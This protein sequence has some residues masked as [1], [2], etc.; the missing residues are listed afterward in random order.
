MLTIDILLWIMSLLLGLASGYLTRELV[1]RRRRKRW[2]D[3]RRYFIE[4]PRLEMDRVHIN[5]SHTGTAEHLPDL[6]LG[7][8]AKCAEPSIPNS[9]G[10][11][12]SPVAGRT[13]LFTRPGRSAEARHRLTTSAGSE[14]NASSTRHTSDHVISTNQSSASRR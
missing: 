2:R 7:E 6:S 3:R 13:Q 4:E 1:S 12:K 5:A 8:P 9:R 10:P 11:S 14:V